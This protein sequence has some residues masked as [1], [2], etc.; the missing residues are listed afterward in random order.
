M[1]MLSR[2]MEKIQ[3]TGEWFSN[4]VMYKAIPASFFWNYIHFSVSVIR[5][6]LLEMKEYWIQSPTF[7]QDSSHQLL[8]ID[9]IEIY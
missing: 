9:I 1:T 7:S 5:D 2:H 4:T 6:F 3:L 8:F